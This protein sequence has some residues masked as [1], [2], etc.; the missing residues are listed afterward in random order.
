[1]SKV[2]TALKR[3]VAEKYLGYKDYEKIYKSSSDDQEKF[4]ALSQMMI[5]EHGWTEDHLA[6]LKKTHQGDVAKML[7]EL[8]KDL[9]AMDYMSR[10]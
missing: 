7:K 5:I 10:F 4:D 6:V 8:E 3:V 2:V 1:M 9:D